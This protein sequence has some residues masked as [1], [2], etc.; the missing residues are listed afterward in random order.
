MRL[1]QTFLTTKWYWLSVLLMGITLEAVALYYQYQVGDE[2]CQICI[3][4]RIWVAA[5]TLL[6]LIMCCLPQRQYLSIVGHLLLIGAG[7]GLWER[8]WFLYQL[9]NGIGEGSCQFFLGFPQWFAL[10][11]WFPFMF[12][13]RNLCG[14]TPE[15]FAGISMAEWLLAFATVAI[16]VAIYALYLSAKHSRGNVAV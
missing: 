9:E 8:S 2:P 11:Q 16:P 1:L 12:E 3:H 14:Y 13:V 6:A 7:I 4:V 5:F 10:D 15:L